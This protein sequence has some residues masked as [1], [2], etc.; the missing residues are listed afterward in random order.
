MEKVFVFVVTYVNSY[1]K[2]TLNKT[3]PKYKISINWRAYGYFPSSIMS[4][5]EDNISTVA[6]GAKIEYVIFD[7]DGG[8]ISLGSKIIIDMQS[9]L[10]VGLMVDSERV[11]TEV[12]S[13]L[14]LC[15]HC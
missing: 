4:R 10:L 2:S 13:E 14:T 5:N 9:S 7:F 3:Y 6:K 8:F 1:L 12:T 11:Y 15:I